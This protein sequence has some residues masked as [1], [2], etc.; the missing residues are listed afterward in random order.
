ML[1]K[2]GFKNLKHNLLMN[3]LTILQMTFAFVILI[4]I[5]STIVSRFT[6]YAPISDYLNK[7]GSFYNISYA[8]NPE[9]GATLRTTDEIHD[10]LEYDCDISAQYDVFLEFDDPNKTNENER[11]ADHFISYD[12]KFAEIF[13]PELESGTWFNLNREPNDIVPVVVSQNSYDFNVGDII[14]LSLDGVGIKAE[15]IGIL[16]DGAK[17]IDTSLQAHEK[18]D[19]RNFYR[20]YKYELEERVTF[21]MLQRDLLDKPVIMQL[22]GN[23]FVTYPENTVDPQIKTNDSTI[24][25]LQTVYTESTKIMRKNSL[26]YI[27]SQLYNL[28]PIF[29][30]VFILTLVGA[31][32]TAALSAKRQLKNYAVYYICGLKWKQ[33]AAVN[34][35]SSL[36]CVLI[37]F[38]LS[39]GTALAAK[40]SGIIGETVI[41]I[42]LWQIV[43]CFATIIIYMLLS[44]ILPLNIIG[45]STPNQLLK[46]N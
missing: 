37:S 18:I 1:L 28:I 33:C 6:Y 3:V 7:K 42:G 20:N 19:F 16:K 29:I 4:S 14:S 24:R 9:T 12:D 5:I 21:I 45:R 30:C 10:L 39:I 22:N 40:I 15:I 43:G 38:I 35:F 27:F 8:I 2:L 44:L 25:R 13:I 36:I 11:S 41:E 23:I 32:S 17:I 26:E 34:F 31:V 46:S